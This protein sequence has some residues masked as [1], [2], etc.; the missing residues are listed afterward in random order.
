MTERKIVKIPELLYKNVNRYIQA[1]NLNQEL[2]GVFF[3]KENVLQAFLPCPNV[4]EKKDSQYCHNSN[5][6]LAHFGKY[7]GLD[8]IADM[9]TH[10][11][12]GSLPSEAD[13]T[14]AQNKN[15]F[16]SVII[17]HRDIFVKD[18]NKFSWFAH[19]KNSEPVK[20]VIIDETYNNTVASLADQFHMIDFGRVLFSPE[21]GVICESKL[22][23]DILSADMDKYKIAQWLQN[24]PRSYERSRVKTQ[25]S[26]ETGVPLVKVNKILPLL[27]G[28]ETK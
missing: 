10:P 13:R 1:I 20:I 25:I 19:T 11:E 23:S 27:L 3:G 16:C 14:N 28:S 8:Q 21:K 9:H 4:A 12:T 6:E 22:G 5:P 24:H 17:S 2:G 26:R 18:D 7:T 15:Y